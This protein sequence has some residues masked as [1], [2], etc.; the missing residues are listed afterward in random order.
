M[1][2][3]Q[4]QTKWAVI[5]DQGPLHMTAFPCVLHYHIGPLECRYNVR[6]MELKH[7]LNHIQSPPL[8]FKNDQ[9]AA[10]SCCRLISEETQNC[11]QFSLYHPAEQGFEME[12]KFGHSPTKT[13]GLPTP[14][15]AG[16]MLCSLHLIASTPIGF[17]EARWLRSERGMSPGH[18]ALI[19]MDSP[20]HSDISDFPTVSN[21]Q[22]EHEWKQG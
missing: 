8:L 11:L 6:V 12:I 19:R 16:C 5:R 3:S 15:L 10:I 2:T 7:T 14:L 21:I 13:R 17:R 22:M 4:G 18:S 20:P 1:R 9:R